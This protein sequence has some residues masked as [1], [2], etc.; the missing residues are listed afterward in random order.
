MTPEEMRTYN[1]AV[2]RLARKGIKG[3]T[4][5]II[6]LEQEIDYYR[7]RIDQLRHDC[8]CC[9]IKKAFKEKPETKEPTKAQNAPNRYTRYDYDLERYVVPLLY[10]ADGSTISFYVNTGRLK[11]TDHDNGQRTL[12]GGTPDIVY[13]E[14][15]D[16]LAELENKE[17]ANR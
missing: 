3:P 14:V 6:A 13:G 11:Y 10:K 1:K 9:P 8:V 15:I 2:Q 4:A 12:I 17:E 16:R 5:Q 7:N